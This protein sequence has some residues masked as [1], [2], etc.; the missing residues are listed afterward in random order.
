MLLQYVSWVLIE[1]NRTDLL[2]FYILQ[3]LSD[4][5]DEHERGHAC[6]LTF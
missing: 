4:Y 1:A 3:L 6:L 2:N 5:M